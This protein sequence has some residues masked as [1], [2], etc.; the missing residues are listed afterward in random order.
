MSYLEDFY[1]QYDEEG[2]LLSH[3]GKVEYLTTMK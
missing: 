1:N 3:H 2:R